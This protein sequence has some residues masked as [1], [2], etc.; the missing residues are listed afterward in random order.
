M[1][2]PL[3]E[4]L[5]TDLP[6]FDYKCFGKLEERVTLDAAQ[7]NFKILKE[8]LENTEYEHFLD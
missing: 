8:A 2:L 6:D 1:I 4:F 5:E 7:I 3:L